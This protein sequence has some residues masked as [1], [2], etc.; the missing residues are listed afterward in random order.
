MLND[1]VTAYAAEKGL[2]AFVVDAPTPSEYALQSRDGQPVYVNTNRVVRAA[3]EPNGRRRIAAPFRLFG[4][5]VC[6]QEGIGGI[7]W[8][9]DLLRSGYVFAHVATSDE[10]R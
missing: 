6:T 1:V 2:K 7:Y 5:V 9:L 8:C 10:R 4:H 3:T